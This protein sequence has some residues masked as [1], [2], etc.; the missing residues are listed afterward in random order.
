MYRK[1]NLGQI[2]ASLLVVVLT[3][4]TGSIAEAGHSDDW[5]WSSRSTSFLEQPGDKTEASESASKPQADEA[6]NDPLASFDAVISGRTWAR[7]TFDAEMDGDG[8]GDF[9]VQRYAIQG[10]VVQTVFDQSRLT[11]HTGYELNHFSFEGA[12][13]LVPGTNDPFTD[14]HVAHLGARL[15]TPIDDEWGWGVLGSAQFSGESSAD[16]SDSVTGMGAAITTYRPNEEFNWVFGLSVS[17]QLEDDVLV[18]PIIDV[19]WN[20]S[21]DWNLKAGMLGG[22]R[23]HG[24]MMERTFASGHLLQFGIGY[25][26][27]RFRLEDNSVSRSRVV[28]D[29]SIPVF[30]DYRMKV[31]DNLEVAFEGGIIVYQ[32]FTVE[33]QTG[34]NKRTFESDP[35][36]FFGFSAHFT[37]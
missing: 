32:E 23:R 3:T 33:N 13:K 20:F 5:H 29:T 34:D 28:Q 22:T 35:T 15:L 4:Q 30:A 18:L 9:G 37:F 6:D 31:N 1:M 14:V 21:D 36:P 25:R 10:S 2:G 12:N 11:F 19:N 17:T 27:D 8:N 16:F 24:I 26:T 7:F